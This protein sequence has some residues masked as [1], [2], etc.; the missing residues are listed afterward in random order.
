MNFLSYILSASGLDNE[1]EL[2]QLI[3][4]GVFDTMQCAGLELCINGEL[5]LFYDF[6]LGSCCAIV[7]EIDR[8]MGDIDWV[9]AKDLW[10]KPCK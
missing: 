5:V 10:L 2:A 3:C 1:S 4:D 7:C 8:G 6:V 9:F